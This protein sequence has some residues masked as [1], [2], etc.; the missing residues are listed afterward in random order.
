MNINEKDL[1]WERNFIVL[2]GVLFNIRNKSSA[3]SNSKSYIYVLLL[4]SCPNSGFLK[5]QAFSEVLG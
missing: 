4:E 5:T 1:K 2:K 3:S